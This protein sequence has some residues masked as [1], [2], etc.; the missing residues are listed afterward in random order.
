MPRS[1]CPGTHGYETTVN[2]PER[3]SDGRLRVALSAGAA[4]A[5]SPSP[6]GRMMTQAISCEPSANGPLAHPSNR[7]FGSLPMPLR[8]PPPTRVLTHTDYAASA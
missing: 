6:S 4:L 8:E 2:D 5:V 1:A 7:L 3:P